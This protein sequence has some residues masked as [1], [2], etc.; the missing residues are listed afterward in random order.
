MNRLTKLGLSFCLLIIAGITL[1]G[2][3]LPFGPAKAGLQVMTT[4]IP[5]SVFLNGQYLEKTP[6]IGKNLKP[7]E[8]LLKVQPDDPEYV[9]YETTISL[10]KGLLTVVT[11][12]PGT[13]PETSGGV[14][15]EMESLP[16]KR[17]EI[18]IISI[19]DKAIV[20][21]DSQ[22]KDFTPLLLE[23]VEEGS[24]EF[25]IRLPSYDSQKH[26]INVIEGYRINITVKMAKQSL[27]ETQP[28]ELEETGS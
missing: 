12:K 19:P 1:S 25:E 10:N 22:Q 15:Y 20:S 17:T 3:T 26:T 16:Q 21:L 14:I 6:Y 23:N 7:G 24:H 27:A 28:V 2:C 13:R 11:W 4:E 8:Y 9:P 18:S 5:A